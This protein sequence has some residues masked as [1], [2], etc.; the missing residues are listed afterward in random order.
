MQTFVHKQNQ[1]QE[2]AN[3]NFAR[4]NKASLQ[5]SS[6]RQAITAMRTDHENLNAWLY[7]P[8]SPFF[9]HDSGQAPLQAPATRVIQTKPAINQPGDE[10]EQEADHI[11]EQVMRMPEPKLQRAC[12]CGGGCPRCVTNDRGSAVGILQAKRTRPADARVTAVPPVVNE[13]LRSEGQGLDGE[14]S[15][16][17]GP[18]FGQDFAGVRVHTGAKAAES[19]RALNARA[20]TV[21]RDVVFAQGQYQPATTSGRQLIAHELTHVVQQS[22]ANA[23]RFQAKVLDDDEHLPCRNDPDKSAAKLTT[24]ENKAAAMADDAASALRA[25][26]LGEM[27]RRLLWQKFRLDYNDPAKRC[28]FVP[29]IAD[30]FERIAHDIRNEGIPY[31]CVSS[32]EPTEDCSGHW[33]ATRARWPGGGYRMD[34]CSNFWRDKSDQAL[35][36]LHEWAHYVF[37]TRGLRDELPGGF[38]TAGCYS[39]FALEVNGNL[40]NPVED[41]KCEPNPDP[42]PELDPTRVGQSCPSNVFLN[43]SLTGG[44]A[45]GMPGRGGGLMTGGRFELLFPRT[46]MH[47]KEFTLGAQFLRLAPDKP[48]ERAAYM[49]GIRAGLQWRQ[50]P[51][52]FDLQFG[53]YAEVGGLTRPDATGDR[54]VPYAGVGGTVG[55]NIPL[56]RQR[57]LELFVDLGAREGFDTKNDTHFHWFQG[58]LGV[59]LTLP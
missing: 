47:E 10:Y 1:P 42:V 49:F 7:A 56:S 52:S 48:D 22:G 21:G 4:S 45:G 11:A 50:Q 30:R 16:F 34:L 37:W 9:T 59:A 28:R 20:Y 58:G 32:G 14:T 54:T 25:R 26:P 53:G 24:E 3:A 19:A 2:K 12:A 39:A 38:D 5:S 31:N 43:F 13:V 27:A 57:A 36:L 17:F 6:G 46:R 55:I 33:A 18:R 51:R 40:A 44:Y 29:E 23:P 35:T 15:R 41:T 8:S